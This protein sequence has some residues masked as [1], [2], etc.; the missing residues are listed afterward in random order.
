MQIWVGSRFQE[1]TQDAEGLG[2]YPLSTFDLFGLTPLHM[3]ARNARKLLLPPD[4]SAARRLNPAF[5]KWL[6]WLLG[7]AGVDVDAVGPESDSD[8]A[9][10]RLYDAYGQPS[11]QAAKRGGYTEFRFALAAFDAAG[12]TMTGNDGDKRVDLRTFLSGPAGEDARALL[13]SLKT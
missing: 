6:V 7:D 13:A 10:Q 1:L 8:T 5:G 3:F 9:L 4:G 11:V 2:R 12:A